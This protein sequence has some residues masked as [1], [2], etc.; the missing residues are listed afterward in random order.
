MILRDL[1]HFRRIQGGKKPTRESSEKK[2]EKKAKKAQAAMED[3]WVDHH[4][5]ETMMA[6]P[7]EPLAILTSTHLDLIAYVLVK[8]FERLTRLCPV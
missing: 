4:G 7:K 6:L 5:V 1:L 2:S 8:A 3:H